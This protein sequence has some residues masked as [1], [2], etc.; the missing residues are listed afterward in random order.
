MMKDRFMPLAGFDRSHGEGWF[1]EA[2][3]RDMWGVDDRAFFEQSLQLVDELEQQPRPWMLTLLTSGTHHPYRLPPE[4]AQD[5]L[6]RS[7]PF[8]RAIRYLDDAVVDFLEELERRGVLRDALVVVTADES[9]GFHDDVDAL[10]SNLGRNWGPLIVME[11][12][13]A[14][15]RID[16]PYLQMDLVPSILDYLGRE[17]VAASYPGRS[18][19]R[20]Y[21]QARSFG[22]GNVYTR[23]VF[24]VTEQGRVAVCDDQVVRCT[25]YTG[26]AP[27][28]L[29]ST[30]HAET[31]S[32]DGDPELVAS[33]I[34]RSSATAGSLGGGTAMPLLAETEVEVED[35]TLDTD[36]QY[37]FGGQLLQIPAGALVD[38]EIDFELLG[39]PGASVRFWSDL[40]TLRER[41][42]L[43]RSDR[44]RVGQR[45]T[46]GYS[47]VPRESKSDV[48]ARLW[49]VKIEGDSR[50]RFRLAR[51]TLTPPDRH[52]HPVTGDQ[53]VQRVF[54][55]Q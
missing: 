13:R 22:F 15:R 46:I 9:N 16:A 1:R 12:G 54:T 55:V 18:V 26:A 3:A 38:V 32:L 17:R 20:D 4:L 21:Q 6:N 11:P 50:L 40:G 10:L 7:S 49:V 37:V 8:A 43:A 52:R 5:T 35:H 45:V 2:Y 41:F 44:V 47:F 19:F 14:S 53:A 31:G 39:D 34:E 42:Y 27:D 36:Q 25:A 30:R 24:G 28:G 29:F 51:L 48:D 23:L 33:M